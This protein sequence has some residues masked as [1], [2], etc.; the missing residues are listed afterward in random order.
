M[1]FPA[2]MNRRAIPDDEDAPLELAQQVFDELDDLQA[3]EAALVNSKHR[4]AAGSA[5]RSPRG[6]SN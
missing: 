1:D 6:S 2:A 4:S 3:L 5:R